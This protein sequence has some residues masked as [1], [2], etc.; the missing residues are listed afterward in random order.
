M[1]NYCV[2][3]VLF[4]GVPA[5]KI[6]QYGAGLELKKNPT[7]NPTLPTGRYVIVLFLGHWDRKQLFSYDTWLDV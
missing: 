3:G 5:R 1:W 2:Y 4:N 6:K 7:K